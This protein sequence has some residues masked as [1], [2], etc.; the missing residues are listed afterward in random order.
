MFSQVQ[1]GILPSEKHSKTIAFPLNTF[2]SKLFYYHVFI[3]LDETYA[4]IINEIIKAIEDNSLYFSLS[5]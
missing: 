4:C 1:R 3:V 5:L 2:F